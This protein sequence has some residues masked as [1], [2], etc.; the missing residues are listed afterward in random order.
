MGD[1]IREK[2]ESVDAGVEQALQELDD[3]LTG[4]TAHLKPFLAARDALREKGQEAL[5][6]FEKAG[7]E[8]SDFITSTMGHHNAT[9]DLSAKLFSVADWEYMANITDEEIARDAEL[10]DRV[11]ASIPDSLKHITG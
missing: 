8:Y 1:M 2:V 4:A 3:R 9:A 11:E 6:A 5:E 7:K 10:F